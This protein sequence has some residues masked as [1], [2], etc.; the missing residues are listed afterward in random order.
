MGVLGGG[1]GTNAILSPGIIRLTQ[2]N[3]ISYAMRLV[4]FA[5]FQGRIN[6]FSS[7]FWLS[8]AVVG[9]LILTVWQYY[10]RIYAVI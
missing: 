10:R 8:M 4:T 5:F 6:L 3:P 9:T 7:F 1:F 2:L